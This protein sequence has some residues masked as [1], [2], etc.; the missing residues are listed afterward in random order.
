MPGK[1]GG[2]GKVTRAAKAQVLLAKTRVRP[3][4]QLNAK[5]GVV[6]KF[7]VRIQ[8]QVIGKQVDVMRQ[9]QGKSLLHPAR[10]TSV[11]TTPEQTMVHEDGVCIRGDSRFDQRQTGGHTRDD[12]ADLRTAL[13]LQAVRSVVLESGRFQQSIKGVE[14]VKAAGHAQNVANGATPQSAQALMIHAI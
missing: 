9:Q 2:V 13:H 14:Q 4:P 5:L 8:W 7:G 10:D 3:K 6:A 12:P 11:L 1:R